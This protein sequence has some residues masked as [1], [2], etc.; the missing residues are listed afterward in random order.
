MKKALRDHWPEYLMEA[1]E[2]G[3]FMISAAV[4]GV[5]LEHSASPIRRALPDAFSRRVLMGIAMGLTA[6]AIIYSPIGKRSG[7]HF[8]PAVT[9]TFFRL[10]KIQRW[11]AVFYISAQFAGGLIGLLLCA[12]LLRNWIADPRVNY[13][14]T[15]PG[16]NGVAI[17]FVAEAIITFILMTTI[18][19][20]SNN[21]K[22]ARMTG[23]FAGCLVAI[24]IAFEAPYSGMS[25][26]P[27]RTLASAVPPQLWNTLWI[28]FT[29]PTIGMLS[30]AELYVRQRG[31]H[32][33]ICAKLHHHNDK[34]CIFKCGY[35]G[36]GQ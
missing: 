29:A 7:A 8:N 9:L 2:L 19:H 18:L 27:A 3:L 32:N 16:E 13:V 10:G 4:F 33:V 11:D 21:Q 15:L 5:I 6:I 28:Y 34:R 26:N 36:R 23:I 17:A 24:Y 35:M 1:A 22:L 14:A 30:A 31:I 20:V 25:M 12:E